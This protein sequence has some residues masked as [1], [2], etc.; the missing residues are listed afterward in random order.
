M[1]RLLAAV[2]C[3]SLSAA[4]GQEG[5]IVITKGKVNVALG[6]FSG[7]HAQAR[8]ILSNNIAMSGVLQVS[9]ASEAAYTVSAVAN[10]DSLTG[11][12]V[13]ASGATVLSQTFR[14]EARSTV[15]QFTDAVVEKLTGQKGIATTRVTFVSAQSGHKEVYIMDIDGGNLRQLTNDKTISLGPKFSPE[16]GRIAYT[17][18]KSGWPAIWTIDLAARSRSITAQFPGTNQ[19]PA[20]SPDGNTLAVVLSK[21][22]NTDLYTLSASGGGATR[23]TRTRGTEASPTW[24]PDGATIAY[25]S[26][27]RGS[28]QVFTIAASGGAPN[29]VNTQS[30][31]TTEPDWSPDGKRLAYSIRVGGGNQ[32]AMTT[33]ASGEQ[34]VLTSS[35]NNETPSWARNSRHLVHARGGALYLLDSVTRESIPLRINLGRCSEP[36]CSR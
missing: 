36:S 32:I 13:D 8:D 27:D 4:C 31:Y 14:G 9:A 28:P 24:S 30:G 10:T 34:K 1:I 17:S 5:A 18:Y 16:G 22:G 15:H 21:D 19:S 2:L 29:R 25:I 3:L 20:F 35:G 26:D 23:L 33:L 11:T 7:S 6:G 12:V